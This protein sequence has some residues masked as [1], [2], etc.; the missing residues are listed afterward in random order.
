MNIKYT[1]PFTQITNTIIQN[2]EL[3]IYEKIIYIVLCS[4]ANQNRDC[5]PSYK[6]I[7]K[8][9]GCSERKAITVMKTLEEK[10]YVKVK[11][12]K[13]SNGSNR[14]NVYEMIVPGE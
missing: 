11:H 2:I 6:T 7:A 14:S 10:G 4:H 8:E 9:S 3:S 1:T 5:F 13:L 12:R